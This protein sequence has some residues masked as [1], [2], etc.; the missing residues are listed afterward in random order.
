MSIIDAHHHVWDLSV[1]DQPYLAQPMLAPL[2]RNFLLS[3]L[4]PEAA[5]QRVTATV[6][7]QTVTEPGETPELL[8]L[9]ADGGL[10]AGVVGWADL[11]APG[12]SDALAGLRE[13]PGGDHLVGIR[14]P[15][16]VEPD[17]AWLARPAVLRGLAAV[18][19]A[20]LV[21]D[22]VVAGAQLRAAVA[23]AAATPQL[24]FVLDHLGNPELRA[25]ADRPWANALRAFAGLPNTVAKLSGILNEPP[26]GGPQAPAAGR[27]A[28]TAHLRPYY[29]IALSSFG[30]RRL[31][32]GSDWPVSTLTM[33]YAGTV[34]AARTLTAGLSGDEQAAV[35]DGTAR[36]VYRLRPA[37]E[38]SC[39]LAGVRRRLARATGLCLARP[40]C[41]RRLACPGLVSLRRLRWPAGHLQHALDGLHPLRQ[42]GECP[43]DLVDPGLTGHGAAPQDLLRG[44]ALASGGPA[45]CL[46]LQQE[47]PLPD[48]VQ[49]AAEPDQH[50]GSHALT[51]PEQAEQDVLGA[52]VVVAE[53]QRLAQR[54]LQH[55]LG[56]R[57]ERDVPGRREG[58]SA[59]DL[60]DLLA[61]RVQAD[62]QRRQRPGRDATFFVQ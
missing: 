57:R 49:V 58:A 8:A 44:L 53:Q 6:V 41:S 7:V 36:R 56:P 24:T 50:L 39:L 46:A 30:P 5:A 51:L 12:V 29:E 18:A 35:F 9:A 17:P 55:S 21:Y 10:I 33:G 32:F 20:G 52:D 61:H 23:A 13:L 43:L 3:D 2:R 34:A 31:M 54:Q 45:R 15:V 42:P 38:L 40:A 37:G 16:L 22:V 19:E 11:E 25:E 27:A 1:R 26:A 28:G 60:L 48:P 4:E 62:V 59:A 14:H 47:D